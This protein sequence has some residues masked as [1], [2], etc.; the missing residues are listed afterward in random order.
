MDYGAVGGFFMISANSAL[1]SFHKTTQCIYIIESKFIRYPSKANF[2][3]IAGIL[4]Q[5]TARTDII[6][7]MDGTFIRILRPS[8]FPNLY[9]NR[10]GF[11][12]IHMLAV[13][14]WSHKFWFVQAGDAGNTHDSMSFQSSTL[15]SDIEDGTFPM[16]YRGKQYKLLTDSAFR[17]VDYIRKT[18]ATD[19]H[20]RRMLNQ[21]NE[22]KSDEAERTC[23]ECIFGILFKRWRIFNK[24]M[25]E[26]T[27][28]VKYVAIAACA[29]HNFIQD[30]NAE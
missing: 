13:A 9:F 1:R 23:V 10:K 17:Q 8:S 7:A 30:M 20:R 2:E 15:K 26:D 27:N 29:L 22:E 24:P 19:Y 12:A 28:R 25:A 11:F 18:N 16:I 21:P 3:H 14:D 6:G 4:N 5:K